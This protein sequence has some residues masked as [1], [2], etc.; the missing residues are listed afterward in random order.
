M[1]YLSP[2]PWN[3]DGLVLATDF[4][5]LAAGRGIEGLGQLRLKRLW[6]EEGG[7]GASLLSSAFP[8]RGGSG[9]GGR[10]K[11]CP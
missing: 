6:K 8:F 11:Y 10:A 9:E 1:S 7:E 2:V 3:I 4:Q 5:V